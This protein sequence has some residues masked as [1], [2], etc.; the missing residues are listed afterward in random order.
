MYKLKLEFEMPKKLSLNKIYAGAHWRERKSE[1]EMY[2]WE[3]MRSLKGFK[4]TKPFNFPVELHF[5]FIF[6]RNALDC[7]N[8][9][10]MGKMIEDGIIY[11]SILPDDSIKYVSKV[12]Y[13]SIKG[14]ENKIILEINDG[15]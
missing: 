7:S 12:S 9:A 3:V 10:Y 4:I 13:T 15:D 11:K 14:K 6:S 5:T 2:L 8:C 1:K